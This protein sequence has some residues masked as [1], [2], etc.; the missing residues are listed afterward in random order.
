MGNSSSSESS[1]GG[2]AEEPDDIFEPRTG[3]NVEEVENLSAR[4][5][6]LLSLSGNN[7]SGINGIECSNDSLGDIYGGDLDVSPVN[8]SNK[9]L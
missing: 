5:R 2:F 9:L 8:Y 1:N 7:A 3:V 4:T 6:A